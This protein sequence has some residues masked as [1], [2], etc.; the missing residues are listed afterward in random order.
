M[1][2][3]EKLP[4]YC[5]MTVPFEGFGAD[6]VGTIPIFVVSVVVLVSEL[7]SVV[8]IV[9]MWLLSLKL[10]AVALNEMSNSC[11]S[12]PDVALQI[13]FETLLPP[14]VSFVQ[15]QPEGSIRVDQSIE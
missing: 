3:T 4:K 6:K 12:F 14:P 8:S 5:V 9:Q 10:D 13:S 11:V 2:V 7:L 1:T 15:L